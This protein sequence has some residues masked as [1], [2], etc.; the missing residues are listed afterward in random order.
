MAL[1]YII[2]KPSIIIFSQNKKCKPIY[3]QTKPI[4]HI[5]V[6][7]LKFLLK[8]EYL[9]VNYI[10]QKCAIVCKYWTKLTY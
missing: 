3:S 10:K 5:D 1:N 9:K 8:Y 6:P 2:V 4:A 7:L